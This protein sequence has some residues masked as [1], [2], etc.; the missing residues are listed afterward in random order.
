MNLK[1]FEDCCMRLEKI[2]N[3]VLLSKNEEYARN[4]DKLHNFKKAARFRNIEPEDALR[5]MKLKHSVSIDDM[6]DDI[7]NGKVRALDIWEEKIIDEINY[8]KL[9]YALLRERYNV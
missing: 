3:H 9:L 6:I 8:L 5:G 7:A 2:S 4:N 1:D